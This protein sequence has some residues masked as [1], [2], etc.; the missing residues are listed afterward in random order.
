MKHSA[1][2]HVGLTGGI[3]SGK[4]TVAGK[5]K[6]LGAGVL[7]ADSAARSICASN[8]RAMPAIRAE[9]GPSFLAADGSL[10]RDL[11]RETIFR[12]QIAKSTLEAITHP[13]VAIELQEQRAALKEKVIV[14]DIPLLVESPHWRH[15]LDFVVV[16][17][18]ALSEQVRRVM[19]RNG[20]SH[21]TTL[22]IIHSQASRGMRL[23][24]ADFVV[25]NST[26]TIQ[27]LDCQ[28]QE[29]AALLGL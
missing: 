6:A 14:F 25:D 9:F 18:C 20:W 1:H 4:S 28:V 19:S 17:D 29:L 24:A 3:G 5:L 11:M 10:N 7:D 12:D 16:V 21:E 8:G 22:S 27:Q 13:L 26:G 2:L 15:R 23:S